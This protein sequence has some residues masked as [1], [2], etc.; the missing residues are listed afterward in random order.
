LQKLFKDQVR[1]ILRAGVAG[2][3]RILVPLVTSTDQLDF[4]LET[5]G[6]ARDEL[7]REG[8]EYNAR[9]P[10]G[11]MLEVAAA[12]ALVDT[13]AE[14]VDFFALG[15]NDL[16]AS[17]LGI[18]RERPVGATKHDAL[19]P[20]LLRIIAHVVENAHAAGRR[21]CVCGEMASD[22]EGALALAALQV[23]A[24]SVAVQQMPS[25]RQLLSR[26]SGREL[27]SLRPD[28]FR[29]RTAAQVREFLNSHATIPQLEAAGVA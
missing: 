20:G 16:I 13:W 11:V 9:V 14:H 27:A 26:Q 2:N 12:T 15:T 5:I 4:I 19:H 24:L 22:P 23:D 21:V 7:Q 18:D 1:A 28:L 8:L 17:V 3:A 10:L 29:H 6:K 25:I